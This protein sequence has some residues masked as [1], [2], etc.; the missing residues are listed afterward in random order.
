MA[1]NDDRGPG[2][3]QAPASLPH[4]RAPMVKAP[5]G[6]GWLMELS[7]TPDRVEVSYERVGGIVRITGTALIRHPTGDIRQPVTIVIRQEDAARLGPALLGRL[8]AI[9]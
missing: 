7:G 5:D 6:K 4:D 9:M 3:A 2:R 8:Q 1:S